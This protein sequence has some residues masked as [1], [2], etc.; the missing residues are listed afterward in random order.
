MLNNPPPY[1]NLPQVAPHVIKEIPTTAENGTGKV[2]LTL[3]RPKGSE[4]NTLPV[5][6]YF[7]GGGWI[8][9]SF[10]VSE[11]LIKD[12]VVKAHIALI[13][14]EYS[15]SPQVKYPVALEECYS[16]V[17]WVHENAS[18]LNV[19]PSNL[20]VFG[21]SAGGNLTAAISIL[22]KKRG[23]N[24]VIKKQLLLYPAVAYTR[25]EY[26]SFK[27]YGQ[28]DYILSH[29]AMS[30]MASLYHDEKHKTKHGAWWTFSPK[31][32]LSCP[33]LATDE[34]LKDLPRCLTITA[35]CDVLRDEGEHYARR[36]TEVGVD[37]CAVR[38]L[39][40]MHGFT[41]M[42]LDTPQYR[43]ALT[44]MTAFVNE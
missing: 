15:L 17:L 10:K 30:N 25:D 4:N 21:D 14:V 41:T 34:E 24:G 18:S 29:K 33:L 28:G 43:Q 13:Y 7:H 19:D 9:G 5:A 32:V 2:T 8:L 11:K 38:V 6:I 35:E 36:L 37:S 3:V 40:A 42:P 12:L 16:S 39:E 23:H 20:T 22:L 44:L 31:D 27:N 1:E 26:D